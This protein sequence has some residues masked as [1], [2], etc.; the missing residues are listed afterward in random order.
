M[1]VSASADASVRDA[2]ERGIRPCPEYLRLEAMHGIDLLD[3]SRLTP[4][5]RGRSVPTSL[6]HVRSAVRRL[7]EYDVVLSDGEHV[8][9]PLA[10]A[11]T[12]LRIDVR[13]VMIGHHL[14]TPAKGRVFRRLGPGR[15]IDRILIHS[16]NQLPILHRSLDVPA[17]KLRVVPYGIDTSFWAP[18][19]AV[20]EPDLVV[21]AGRE[22][23]DYGTLLDALPSG[24]RLVV[25]DGSSFSPNADRRN[26]TQWPSD[27]VRRAFDPV[28]LRD[29]Y[30]RAAVVVVPVVETTFPAGVTSLLEALS[31]GKAVILSGTSGL[32]SVVPND[33]AVVVPPGDKDALAAA[34]RDLLSDPSKR[35]ALGTRAQQFARR[36]VGLDRYAGELVGHLADPRGLWLSASL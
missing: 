7:R 31:M 16:R 10:L 33:V 26:P 4:R 1:L 27:V 19:G 34:L 18:T 25:A 22:H 3:W 14:D 36:N 32:A 20:E 28:A 2:V 13:H 21:S 29:L 12:R 23:R 24:V 35:H 8:G 6:R 17:S 9:I 11:M 5:P 15:S 30:D